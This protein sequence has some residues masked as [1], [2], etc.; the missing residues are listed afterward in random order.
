M[1]APRGG[2]TLGRRPPVLRKQPLNLVFR[3]G[4]LFGGDVRRRGGEERSV[5]PFAV[6][7]ALA[8]E[9]RVERALVPLD[10]V[11]PQDAR[12]RIELGRG[13]LR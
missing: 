13:S 2:R 7:V 10:D 1:D 5:D 11:A 12:G 3:L 6:D 4:Q 8:G 9:V